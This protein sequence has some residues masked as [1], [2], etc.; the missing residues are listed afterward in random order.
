MREDGKKQDEKP[1]QTWCSWH[2]PWTPTRTTHESVESLGVKRVQAAPRA[3]AQRGPGQRPQR[4]RGKG[5]E[6]DDPR[7]DPRAPLVVV[8]EGSGQLG[9]GE[10]LRHGRLLQDPAVASA[11]ATRVGS[12]V[13]ALPSAI[14]VGQRLDSPPAW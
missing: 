9:Q 11:P 7:V 4:P 3:G 5:Q 13:H 10:H 1:Q 6:D 2:S 8:A 14:C 12:D